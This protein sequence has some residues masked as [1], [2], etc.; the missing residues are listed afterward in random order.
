MDIWVIILIVLI[1]IIIYAMYSITKTASLVKA[2]APLKYKVSIQAVSDGKVL[3]ESPTS[4]NYYYEAWVYL[5]DAPAVTVTEG[6]ELTTTTTPTISGVQNILGRLNGSKKD[7]SLNVVKN[8][9][10]G[11][12]TLC[13]LSGT[14]SSAYPYIITE[15]FPLNKWVYL[16]INV[17]GRVLEVYV[18]G[19]LLR[20]VQLPSTFAERSADAAITIGDSSLEGYITRAIR[21]PVNVNPTQ[22]WDQY[23]QG[24]GQYAGMLFGLLDYINSYTF[25]MNITSD[26][27]VQR[28]FTAQ[29]GQTETR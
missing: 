20:T 15:D 4:Q 29:L 28:Q 3:I 12:Y 21:K 24:N 13:V 8:S 7:V 11:R 23:L 1:F 14:T 25:N 27:K 26:G 2:M 18:N 16:V 17:A 9:G 10:T 19:K 6:T 5:K 22:V